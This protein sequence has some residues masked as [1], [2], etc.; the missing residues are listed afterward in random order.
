MKNTRILKHELE[1]KRLAEKIQ[2]IRRMSRAIFQF[3]EY[4]GIYAI[5]D[6]RKI[7]KD[8]FLTAVNKYSPRA[9]ITRYLM[10]VHGANKHAAD[11]AACIVINRHLSAFTATNE[12]LY[13]VK[14]PG[15]H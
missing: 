3:N 2:T 15:R 11:S 1:S 12:F 9:A 10:T 7:K 5:I 8:D 4:S 14:P 13:S 6:C